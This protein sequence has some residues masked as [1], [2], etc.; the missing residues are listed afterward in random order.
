MSPTSF[1]E[2]A[3]APGDFSVRLH[4]AS[5]VAAGRYEVRCDARLTSPLLPH[6][7]G[8]NA[9]ITLRVPPS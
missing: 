1:P 6:S 4:P 5:T 3:I 9:T 2:H 7:P 8:A